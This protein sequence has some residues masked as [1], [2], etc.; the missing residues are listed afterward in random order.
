MRTLLIAALMIAL[1]AG[2]WL[3]TRY[4]RGTESIGAEGQAG[5]AATTGEPESN[6]PPDDASASVDG[7]ARG[8]DSTATSTAGTLGRNPYREPEFRGALVD[9]LVRSGLSKTDSERVAD[10]AIE[11][12]TECI[13]PIRIDS[14]RAA[15]VL[16]ACQST[17]WQQIGLNK[18]ADRRAI[19]A[20][21]G[22]EL[23]RRHALEAAAAAS[24]R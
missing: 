11:G 7:P 20:A 18:A 16:E 24:P 9:Y 23:S 1:V 19:M 10:A 21:F 2:A 14:A 15:V 17:M 5:V 13:A 22:R 4:P 8:S 3:A 12:L 6:A